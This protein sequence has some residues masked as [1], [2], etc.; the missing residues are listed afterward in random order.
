MLLSSC[1]SALFRIAG[2]EQ[3]D[4]DIE[5]SI[6]PYHRVQTDGTLCVNLTLLKISVCLDQ[7]GKLMMGTDCLMFRS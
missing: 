5:D 1:L 4:N 7:T 3:E 6:L 2:E